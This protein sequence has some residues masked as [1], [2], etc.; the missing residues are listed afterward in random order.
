MKKVFTH[1]FAFTQNLFSV[2]SL[3]FIMILGISTSAFC[4]TPIL[5]NEKQDVYPLGLHL[6]ILEDPSEQLTIH[7]V[8]SKKYDHLFKPSKKKIPNFGF[9]KSAYWVRFHCKNIAKDKLKQWIVELVF[10]NMHYVDFYRLLDDGSYDV[11]QTGTMR[12]VE[13]RDVDFFRYAFKLDMPERTEKTFY[14]RFQNEASM[15]LPLTIRSM[16]TF[17]EDG[18][19][20]QFMV[21]ILMGILLIMW[22]YNLF[23]YISLKDKSYLYYTLTILFTFLFIF[24]FTGMAYRYLWPNLTWW[25]SKSVLFFNA[26][27]LASFLKFVSTFLNMRAR[28]P[29]YNLV[30]NILLVILCIQIV[31]TPFV[32]YRITILPILYIQAFA[33][34]LCIV[35][36]LLSVRQGYRPARYFFV[37]TMFF[38]VTGSFRAFVRLNWV[39]S[40]WFTE[41]GYTI[42]IAIGVWMLSLAL[43]DSIN[44]LKTESEKA[45]LELGEKENK[46]RSIFENIQD[47]YYETTVDGI[48]TEISPSIQQ[49][50]L[51][52]REEL[53]GKHISKIFIDNDQRER[54]LSIIIDE[55]KI[56]DY[57]IALKDKD[58]SLHYI[59]TISLLIK[60][61][62]GNPVKIVGSLRDITERKQLEDKLL[63]VEKMDSISTLAGGIS[64]DFS[65]LLT[66]INGYAELGSLEHD[67]THSCNRYFREIIAT[68]QR[69]SNLT[70][71]LLTFSRKQVIEPKTVN[72]NTV[73]TDLNKMLA[74]LI[75]EDIKI[76]TK[77]KPN[78]LKIKADTNQIE[79]ILI[80]LVV[81]ARD[82]IKQKL[83]V[84]ERKI[85][86]ETDEIFI[87]SSNRLDH[88]ES[89]TGSHVVLS[90]R[91]TGAGI[92]EK[93]IKRIFEPFYT[94]KEKGKGT[95]LGLS[96]IYGIVKQN[97]GNIEIIT[98][99]NK[100]TIFK[101]YWPSCEEKDLK[102]NK[103]A[104]L[105]NQF[106][107]SEKILVVEDDDGARDFT[108]KV[109]QKY[110]YI[111]YEANDGPSAMTLV[112]DKNLHIDMLFT[113]FIMPEM[114]GVELAKALGNILPG[115]KVL[116]T[117][118]YADDQIF[119][120]G[121]LDE[122]IHFI[123]KP[124]SL[125]A[126]VQ[127]VREILDGS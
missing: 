93:V 36:G 68:G 52:E 82:A 4:Q 100:G 75:E 8:I 67:E 46:Y 56:S 63:Q 44:L 106:S 57:E 125:I 10:P 3:N 111:V 102:E 117:S 59:S 110:G 43:A 103:D 13:S 19:V 81:N 80:N 34:F 5:L 65:N 16:K 53:I 69:A 47:V 97:N 17:Y 84:S 71:Q 41:Y 14:M 12:P 18:L 45:N 24:S 27:A 113:D 62:Q 91:D 85:I 23:I 98:E 42:G 20:E 115:I 119:H 126:L 50:S 114:N 40:N 74:R 32:S 95:G 112:Q 6:Q 83:V 26:L 29:K 7:D 35:I 89:N 61:E 121:V 116:Y 2:A 77:L 99:L 11:I 33:L 15:T 76:E 1:I 30:I 118:G 120:N 87:D 64:H 72:I 48:I 70:R 28:L 58:D 79:Q 123:Q 55:G 25:N 105:K 31:L 21:G 122:N 51:Y 107:G 73:I 127:K 78:I 101:I 86:I 60:D 9:T 37:S 124:F 90:V 22:G 109:L 108:I 49:A 88:P 38:L 66:A 96:T 39:S 54:F 94:T 104:I 92:D